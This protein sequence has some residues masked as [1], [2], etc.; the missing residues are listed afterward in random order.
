MYAIVQHSLLLA[1]CIIVVSSQSRFHE[2]KNCSKKNKASLCKLG[3]FG[4]SWAHHS[5]GQILEDWDIETSES[6]LKVCTV[7]V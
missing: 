4:L 6:R 5:D 7:Y 3:L 1:D 2:K